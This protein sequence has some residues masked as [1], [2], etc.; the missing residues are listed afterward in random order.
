M[1]AL[2]HTKM[3]IDQIGKKKRKKEKEKRTS[4]EH[5]TKIGKQL[6]QQNA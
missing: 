3:Y 2:L 1:S 6:F 4:V 5:S